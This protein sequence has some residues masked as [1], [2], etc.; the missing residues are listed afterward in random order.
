MNIGNGMYAIGFKQLSLSLDNPESEMTYVVNILTSNS[1]MSGPPSP[2][3]EMS[4][5]LGE[6]ISQTTSTPSIST[7]TTPPE[8]KIATVYFIS[9]EE[10][11]FVNN[12]LQDFKSKTWN[13]MREGCPELLAENAIYYS[14]PYSC[15]QVCS[16]S[17]E[18][19]RGCVMIGMHL[20]NIPASTYCNYTEDLS[21]IDYLRY[22]LKERSRDLQR[23]YDA[24]RVSV[25]KCSDIG[26]TTQWIWVSVGLVLGVVL[27]S[28][29]IMLTKRKLIRGGSKIRDSLN[30]DQDN[31]EDKYK[32]RKFHYNDAFEFE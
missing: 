5:D 16:M 25:D 3:I 2:V 12:Y 22:K 26:W 17:S 30:N 11:K 23:E 32:A 9:V 19:E 18:T 13:I 8:D 24:G 27:L 14:S 28:L 10:G 31:D 29:V 15:R 21:K 7:T 4:Y 1:V 6:N 20:E